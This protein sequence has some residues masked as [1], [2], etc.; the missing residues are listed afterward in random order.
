MSQ[1]MADMKVLRVIV[2]FGRRFSKDSCMVFFP[3]FLIYLMGF[4]AD[5]YSGQSM[6]YDMG[7]L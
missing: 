3:T 6:N 2:F 1:E 7:L 5:T 4:I